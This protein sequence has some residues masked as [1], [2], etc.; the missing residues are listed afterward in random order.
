MLSLL[1]IPREFLF[2]NTTQ[3]GVKN[4]FVLT[5]FS[6]HHGA[7]LWLCR[8][9]KKV[10]EIFMFVVILVRREGKTDGIFSAFN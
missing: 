10:V 2:F 8:A 5:I 7:S 9:N 1:I 3:F 6:L 4:I